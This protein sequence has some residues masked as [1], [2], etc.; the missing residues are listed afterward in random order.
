[1]P[2]I[3]QLPLAATVSATDE[4]PISQNGTTAAV[5]VA[6]LL[7]GLQPTIALPTAT[8]AGRT[9]LGT[10]GPEAIAPGLGLQM[11]GGQLVATGADHAGFPLHAVAEPTDQVVLASAAGPAR[12]PVAALRGLFSAGANVAIDGNGVISAASSATAPATALPPPAPGNE[13]AAL[14]ATDY[15]AV[16]QNGADGWITY[17]NLLNGQTIDQAEPAA[18]ATDTDAFF[19]AQGGDVLVRQVFSA[20]W[21]YIETKLTGF[22]RPVRELVADT[23]LDATA[24]NNAVLVCSKPL[25]LSANFANMGSGFACDVLNLSAG[26]VIM[27]T[28][29]TVGSGASALPAGAAARLNG[30]SYSAGNAVFWAG[31]PTVPNGPAIGVNFIPTPAPDTAFTVSGGI[32]NDV[33]AAL[34]Y[35]TDGGI[36]WAAAP[37]PAIG[38]GTY[39]FTLPAGLPA[40]LYRIGVRDHANP[41]VVGSSNSFAVAMPASV[42][43]AAPASGTVGVAL[44]LSGFVSPP[45]DAVQVQLATQNAMLPASGWSAATISGGSFSASLIPPAAG[46]FYAWAQD[47]ATGLHAVSPAI[48][49][50]PAAGS[51]Q[52][53]F[54]LLPSGS[55]TAGSGSIGVNANITPSTA[56]NFGFSTS[57]AAKPAAWTAGA[58]AS[59]ALWAAYV[60]VPA[61]AGTYY[62]WAETA[63]GA[64]TAVSASS[65]TVG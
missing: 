54:N 55:Y 33:P 63:D 23:V 27:G 65:F 22:R 46:T 13:T 50:G 25:S 60:P 49:V 20:V 17:A 16:N 64:S 6:T 39:S 14:A 48:A 53:A 34:D 7:A 15:V 42:S 56:V 61:T 11:G 12:L 52:I 9:S 21:A 59:G 44:A 19:V 43:I 2:M 30:I 58:D 10:G 62:T 24:H 32:A 1:M 38:N 37:A 18:A 29:I 57:T 35:S 31:L 41:T 26:P 8:L 36:T 51:V 28:G 47:A 5:P 4:V 40:G 3:P 45:G